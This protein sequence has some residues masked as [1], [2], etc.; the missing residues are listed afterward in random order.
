MGDNTWLSAAVLCAV[1]SQYGN[2]STPVNGFGFTF[3]C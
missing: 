1:H 2:S 3:E